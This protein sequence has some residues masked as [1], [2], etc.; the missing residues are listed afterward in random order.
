MLKLGYDDRE[1]KI[2]PNVVSD[3]VQHLL[4]DVG[5]L[6]AAGDKVTVVG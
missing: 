1:K 5:F 2:C 3:D 6:L 4:V